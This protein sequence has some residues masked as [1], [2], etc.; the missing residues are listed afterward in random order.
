MIFPKLVKEACFARAEL[1]CECSVSHPHH[2]GSCGNRVQRYTSFYHF[3]R[4]PQLGGRAD[5]SN[6]V[7][8]CKQCH[9]VMLSSAE[10]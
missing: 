1:R 10:G 3:K 8:V 7:V 4:S 9:E 2:G 6:C 5:K